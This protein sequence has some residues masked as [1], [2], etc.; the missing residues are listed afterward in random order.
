MY[1]NQQQN[2]DIVYMKVIIMSTKILSFYKSTSKITSYLI[3][4]DMINGRNIRI[5]HA[6]QN[7]S[8]L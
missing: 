8:L 7:L 2:N 4:T 3:H 6:A 1:I 5:K